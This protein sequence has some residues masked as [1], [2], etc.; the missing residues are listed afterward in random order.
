MRDTN[1]SIYVLESSDQELVGK[2]TGGVL[3]AEQTVVCE[4]RPD[5]HQ[6]C[7]QYT[8]L[9]EWR[10]TGMSMNQRYTLTQYDCPK[11]WEECK[12]VWQGC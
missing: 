10:K 3:E 12:V 6:M 8:F 2:Y 5:T 9:P 4:H 7:M 1:D 11:I